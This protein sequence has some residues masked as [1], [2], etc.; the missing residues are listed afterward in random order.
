MEHAASRRDEA[1]G[2]PAASHARHKSV[3]LRCACLQRRARAAWAGRR[4]ERTRRA[5]AHF[6]KSSVEMTERTGNKAPGVF[7]NVKA[8]S[9]AM[10]SAGF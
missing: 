7:L 8:N 3:L 9:Y 4:A 6:S 1:A 2:A 5:Q 10:K